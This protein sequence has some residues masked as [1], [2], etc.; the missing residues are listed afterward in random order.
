MYKVYYSE[1]YNDWCFEA[2]G[3]STKHPD[4]IEWMHE[5]VGFQIIDYFEEKD[6]VFQWL[7]CLA[8]QSTFP[9][10]AKSLAEYA[11]ENWYTFK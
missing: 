7:L 11:L 2:W 4:R 8:S 1:K 9:F 10:H 3:A 6:Q 5:T